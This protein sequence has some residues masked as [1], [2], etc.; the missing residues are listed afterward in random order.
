MCRD[1][2]RL[3]LLVQAMQFPHGMRTSR[4]L[5]AALAITASTWLACAGEPSR[6]PQSTA[7]RATPPPERMG[8]TE[9]QAPLPVDIDESSTAADEPTNP[10]SAPSLPPLAPPDPEALV[11]V[12]ADGTAVTA[13][14]I[15][16]SVGKIPIPAKTS[17]VASVAVREVR[18]FPEDT[19][20]DANGEAIAVEGIDRKYVTSQSYRDTVRFF[21]RS[22][23]KTGFEAKPRMTTRTTTVW[24]VRCP[25]GETAHV[26]VRDT[27]PTTVEV[28]ET[29]RSATGSAN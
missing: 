25:G 3:I 24:T 19:S 10:G 23:A 4:Y 14:E 28:I 9:L 20:G 17:L 22:L 18:A 29:S 6:T 12:R 5:A 8:Q 11:G 13:K 27:R 7:A 21:E 15:T 16:L 1:E 2:P 26:A